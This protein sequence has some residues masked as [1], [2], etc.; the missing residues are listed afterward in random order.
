[1][2]ADRIAAAPASWGICEVPGWGHQLNVDRVL[3]EMRDLGLHVAELGPDGFIPGGPL[4]QRALLE[5]Y[6]LTPLG[7]FCPLVLHEPS[8]SVE[9]PVHEILEAFGVL[10]AD[11]MVIAAASGTDS[12]DQ[13]PELSKTQWQTLIA[14]L[15]T[16]AALAAERGITACVHPHIGTL[17]QTPAEVARVLAHC[18]VPL[19]LDTGHLTVAGCDPIEI[20]AARP[21]RIS[22]VHLKDVVSSLAHSFRAGELDYS[23][24][25]RR[26]MYTRL[27]G[28][29]VELAVVVRLLEGAGYRGWYV[30]ELD[31]MLPGEPDDEGPIVGIRSSIEYLSGLLQAPSEP[32]GGPNHP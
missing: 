26:G 17:I 19:C 20:V 12:Y 27:G 14:N 4:Q 3:S 15:E 10:G 31:Q 28:G 2:L 23:D 1:M 25:V 9:T 21:D 13:R 18:N 29:D 8:Q 22:H 24:A 30:P 16:I 5:S 7:A 11:M 6:G 32:A